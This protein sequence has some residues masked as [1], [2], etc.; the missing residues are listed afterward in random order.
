MSG[1]FNY[2]D[3]VLPTPEG[4]FSMFIN[5]LHPGLGILLTSYY[6]KEGMD[7]KV[8]GLGAVVMLLSFLTD[9]FFYFLSYVTSFSAALFGWLVIPLLCVACCAFC[10]LIP[11]FFR[12]V[13]TLYSVIH[14]FLCLRAYVKKHKEV[15]A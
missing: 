14:C 13:Y 2:M 8:A 15:F 5:C 3:L 11:A 12:V 6:G 10:L 1:K 7:P 9:V 4:H